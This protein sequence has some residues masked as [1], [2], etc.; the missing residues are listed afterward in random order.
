MTCIA[1]VREITT[2]GARGQLG[3]RSRPAFVSSLTSASA[4]A[5]ASRAP[6]ATAIAACLLHLIGAPRSLTRLTPRPRRTQWVRLQTMVLRIRLFAM[7]RECAGAEW[8]DVD[9]HDGATVDEALAELGRRPPLAEL[10]GRL[11]VRMAVN[12]ELV[13][14]GVRLAPEDE[15][16]L[17]PPVSGG[18]PAH[19][20]IT[21]Q[22][23]DAAA[24]TARVRHPS[25]GALVTFEGTVRDVERLDYE[26]YSEMA[27]ARMREIL[28]RMIERHGLTAAAAEHRIGAVALG[29]PGVVV[30][31]SAPHR[32]AAFAG[33]RE[34]IDEIKARAPIWKRELSG[35]H[36]RWVG[37]EPVAP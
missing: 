37:G 35:E 7:L 6:A 16:A 3:A 14:S 33:A 20:L 26:A 36:A 18:A 21:E 1:V 19:V 8:I 4:L 12:R 27:L 17:L 34:A 13:A 31:V 9:L 10:L 25:A 29:E 24:V 5:G 30:A 15:L 22:P 28:E 23:L 2:H 32:D 11:P